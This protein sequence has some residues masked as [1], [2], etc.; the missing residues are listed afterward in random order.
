MWC[1]AAQ[2]P[3][4]CVYTTLPLFRHPQD[5]PCPTPR[6]SLS[7]EDGSIFEGF[8]YVAPSFLAE[9]AAAAAGDNGTDTSLHH[10]API[11]E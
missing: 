7:L 1:S 8:S 4:A 11:P 6:D 2:C 10:M 5:S 9:A 3:T